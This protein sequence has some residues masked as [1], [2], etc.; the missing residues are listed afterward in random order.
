MPKS[1]PFRK[2]VC[3]KRWETSFVQL[4]Q[5]DKKRILLLDC[6]DPRIIDAAI[7]IGEAGFASPILLTTMTKTPRFLEVFDFIKGKRAW[8]ERLASSLS[9]GMGHLDIYDREQA[10]QTGALL[11]DLGYVDAAIAGA[12]SSSAEVIKAGLRGVGPT[13]TKTVSSYF[14]MVVGDNLMS[15]ADCAVIPEPDAN[16]LAQIAIDTSDNYR[17]LVDKKPSVAFLS[18][19]TLGSARH[20]NV[21]KV[22]KAVQLVRQRRPGLKVDG[23]LQFDAAYVPSV[24]EKKAPESEVAGKANVYIFPDLQSANIG[25]KLAERLGGASA[26]GPI[27]Q[28]LKKP[29]LDL[30]RGCSVEDIVDLALIAA[31][32]ANL[33]M[34]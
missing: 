26:I 25:Y 19:S 17:S 1:K 31:C 32:Q 7:A 4:P 22:Q 34:E 16:Q 14:L 27:L 13:A 18:F 3:G 33:R 24:A 12:I 5:S 9:A 2:T 29:W 28:G 8:T 30:S 11:L 23:E 20:H 15:F 6:E 21:D 10:L